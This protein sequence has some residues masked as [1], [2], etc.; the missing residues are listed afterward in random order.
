MFTTYFQHPYCT[1]SI[2]R[3][4]RFILTCLAILG[5]HSL[6]A[7]MSEQSQRSPRDVSLKGRCTSQ[8][9]LFS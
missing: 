4:F 3:V 2:V 7:E 8:K 5:D 6:V 9:H 1:S